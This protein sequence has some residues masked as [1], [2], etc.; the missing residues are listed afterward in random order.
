M[1]CEQCSNTTATCA[2]STTN[3]T[4]TK[5]AVRSTLSIDVGCKR[6]RVRDSMPETPAETL[7][8][9]FRTFDFKFRFV[10]RYGTGTGTGYF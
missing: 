10:Y 6:Q 9:L 4:A 5:Q 7:S 1:A 2:T 8:R 3:D